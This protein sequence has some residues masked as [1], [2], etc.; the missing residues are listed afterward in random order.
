MASIWSHAG[1]GPSF[2]KAWQP[3][4]GQLRA[5]LSLGDQPFLATAGAGWTN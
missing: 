2:P 3:S 1:P 5:Q 4:E